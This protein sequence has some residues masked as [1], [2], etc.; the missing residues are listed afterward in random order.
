[1]SRKEDYAAAPDV[2]QIYLRK[3]AKTSSK[4]FNSRQESN[5]QDE[6]LLLVGTEV[7]PV[8]HPTVDPL[9]ITTNED[10]IMDGLISRTCVTSR[11][12]TGLT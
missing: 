2:Y 1:M 4:S 6:S 8:E 7:D 9:M 12:R 5:A 3:N 10:W 11:T